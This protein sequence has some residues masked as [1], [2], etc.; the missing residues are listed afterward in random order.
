MLC[1]L[2]LVTAFAKNDVGLSNRYDFLHF[3]IWNKCSFNSL[4]V[5]SVFH[6]A[7]L[8]VAIESVLLHRPDIRQGEHGQRGLEGVCGTQLTCSLSS[9]HSSQGLFHQ[10]I[11]VQKKLIPGPEN[12]EQG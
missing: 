11:Q 2:L 9:S 3:R 6:S 4:T 5:V 12:S 1:F 8:T 7:V 10:T